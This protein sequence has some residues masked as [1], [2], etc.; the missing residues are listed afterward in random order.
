[1]AKITKKQELIERAL[2]LYKKDYTLVSISKELDIHTS[3]LRR[4]LRESG[5]KA[6]GSSQDNPKD[7]TESVEAESDLDPR[8]QELSKEERKLDEHNARLT[9]EYLLKQVAEGQASP[10]E[11]YQAYMAATALQLIRDG[12]KNFKAP[13]TP[14]ELDT[15]DQIARRNLGLNA[16]S[17]G[18][19]GKVQIDISILN[20]T[21][22]DRGKGAIEKTDTK[23]IDADTLDK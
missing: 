23:I 17:G 11:I 3:T 15:L 4:W 14:R 13:R 22:A 10:A 16:K 9:E 2:E 20:N 18:G 8:K 1:M 21:K 19:S 5:V 7:K 12:K 6:K